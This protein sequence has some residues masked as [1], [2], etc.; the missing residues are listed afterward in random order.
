MVDVALEGVV[1]VGVQVDV[2]ER[3]VV[4]CGGGYAVAYDVAEVHHG[5]AELETC[6]H[7]DYFVVYLVV[8]DV[9][10]EVQV[11]VVEVDA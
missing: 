4:A 2:A 3:G 6:W 1:D 10:G 11:F 7:G 5:P 8:V 9:D